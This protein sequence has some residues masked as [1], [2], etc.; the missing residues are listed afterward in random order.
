[1]NSTVDL[2]GETMTN[3]RWA[4]RTR[5]LRKRYG[6]VV[7]LDGVDLEVPVGSVV[8]LAGPNGAGKTTLLKLLLDLLPPDGGEME[9]LGRSPSKAGARVR[10]GIGFL[11]ED[12]AFP[13]GRMRV[14]AV[15][16]FHAHF[17]PGWDPEYADRLASSLDLR[18][19]RAWKGLSKGEARRAQFVTALAH[20]PPLLL[21]DEPTDGLDPVVRE[22]V[23]SLLAEHLAETGAT[24]LYCT[25]VLHE[26]QSIADRLLVLRRG[27]VQ[28]DD[29]IDRLRH[30]HRRVRLRARTPGAGAPEPPGF[31]V[32]EEGRS[33]EG[34]RWVVSAPEAE[35]RNWADAHSCELTDVEG[36]SV[37]DT[38]LAYLTEGGVR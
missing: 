29:E 18:L 20:R 23:L 37:A 3:D 16:D 17:R 7:A 24:T 36:V 5:G 10:A 32:R 14:R 21:L 6:K 15:L 1:M 22:R 34:V 33:G 8:L 2:Q 13:F 19:D 11:P 12:A 25:H 31:V 28:V 26:A 4:V 9:V 27:A 35:V 38:A 30:T